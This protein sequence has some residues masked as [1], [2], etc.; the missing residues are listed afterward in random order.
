[1][2]NWAIRECVKVTPDKDLNLRGA[3]KAAPV[4]ASI[5]ADK[6]Q[7][8]KSG[9]FSSSLLSKCKTNPNHWVLIVGYG[10]EGKKNYWKCKNSWGPAW[11]RS[12]YLYIERTESGEGECGI[13]HDAYFPK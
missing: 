12:G 2:K 6:L 3:V 13:Q 8:Y 7:S 9:V 5:N 4:A 1:M 10:V 11:G